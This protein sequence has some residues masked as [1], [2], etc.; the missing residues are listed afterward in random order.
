VK[1]ILFVFFAGLPIVL[2]G[3]LS[4]IQNSSNIIVSSNEG[5]TWRMIIGTATSGKARGGVVTHLYIPSTSTT[6]LVAAGPASGAP[7]PCYGL[8]NLEWR[9][10]N[11]TSRSDM[12][13]YASISS[14]N[15][16]ENTPQKIVITINGRWPSISQYLKTF[17][18]TPQGYMAELRAAYSGQ[19]GTKS[20][21]WLFTRFRSDKING[22]QVTIKDSNTGPIPLPYRKECIC[23]VPSGIN[24]PYTVMWPFRAGGESLSLQVIQFD[25]L[26]SAGLNYEYWPAA[27]GYYLFF[28]R[29]VSQFSNKT[30][31]FQWKWQFTE[32]GSTQIRHKKAPIAMNNLISV[33]P[34]PFSSEIKIMLGLEMAGATMRLV[35][36]DGRIVKSW[37]NLRGSF[38]SLNVP[39]VSA[40]I[41][42]IQAKKNQRVIQK[43][44]LYSK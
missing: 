25:G 24:F 6:N 18:I 39:R 34:N 41:Y 43:R 26:S 17:T 13:Q 32:S 7:T 11:P 23:R 29:W 31:H 4:L 28:P 44:V 8:D 10:T 38:L 21:W 37:K 19:T 14:L 35:D 40:G 9:H 2:H 33:C 12:A 22:D 3:Q 1:K 42:F 5:R 16:V 15:V 20:M 30:Y 36:L 27:G